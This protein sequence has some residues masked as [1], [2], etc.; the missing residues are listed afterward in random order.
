M[1]LWAS[2]PLYVP[3]ISLLRTGPAALVTKTAAPE[4]RGEALGILDATSSVA[5]VVT[6]LISGLAYDR[7]GPAAPFGLQAL[8]SLGGAAALVG[9]TRSRAAA[10]EKE[11]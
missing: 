9:G 3:A 8:L 1:L 2:L 5:R 10:R 11:E 6:P 7:I 4:V